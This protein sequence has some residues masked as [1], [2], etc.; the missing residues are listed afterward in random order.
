[1]K[2]VK[3]MI[4]MLAGLLALGCAEDSE[5]SGLSGLA[6]ELPGKPADNGIDWNVLKSAPD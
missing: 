5:I 6:I 2:L 1:M 3:L 4:S